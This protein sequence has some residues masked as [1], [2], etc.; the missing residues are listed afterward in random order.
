MASTVSSTTLNFGMVSVGIRLQK[1]AN[2]TGTAFKMASPAG[3]PVEQ[4]Y[5]DTVTGELFK[6]AD[7][8]KAVQAPDG[9]YVPVSKDTVKAIDASVKIEDL[10]I[11]G[12][13]DMTDVPMERSEGAYFVAPIKGA[14]P[15]QVKPLALLASGL[16][17][18]G[19]AGHGKLT[20]RSIQRPFVVYAKDGAL[21]LNVLTFADEFISLAE[22]AEQLSSV[23]VDEKMTGLAAT[24]IEAQTGDPAALN[25]YTNEATPLREKLIADVLDGKEVHAPEVPAAKADENQDLEALLLASIGDTPKATAKAKS[26]KAA[27]KVAA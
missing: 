8:G 3:N 7:L 23:E 1:A 20:L 4:R 11:D 19:K 6:P 18:T 12:F 25:G 14:T 17:A 5:V 10:T 21:I 15:A 22:A 27:A 13:I 16:K 24:L 2:K 26:K 9:G